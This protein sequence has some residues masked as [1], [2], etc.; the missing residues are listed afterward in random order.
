M[1]LGRWEDLVMPG[2][3]MP[4]GGVMVVV[5]QD[6]NEE[7]DDDCMLEAAVEE[8]VKEAVEADK[9]PEMDKRVT[10]RAIERTVPEDG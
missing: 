7:G 1:E 10:G 5:S 3:E 9:Q 6:E 4:S 8:P 2:K